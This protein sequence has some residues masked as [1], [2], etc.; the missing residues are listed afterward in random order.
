MFSYQSFQYLTIELTILFFLSFF[1]F[2]PASQENPESGKREV[3][4]ERA[5]DKSGDV[6]ESPGMQT[7]GHKRTV[8]DPELA[9]QEPSSESSPQSNALLDSGDQDDTDRDLDIA[10][11]T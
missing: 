9:A 4:D 10:S 2:N 1:F 7:A 5:R 8:S 3:D 6:S 11:D